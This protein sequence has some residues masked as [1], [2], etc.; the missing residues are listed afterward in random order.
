MIVKEIMTEDVIYVDKNEDLYH[1]LNLMKKHDITK[2]PVVEDKKLIGIVTDNMIAYKL[3]SI[4][5]KG[6]PA[7]R[8]HASLVTEKKFEAI[9]PETDIKHILQ[10]VGRPGL[11]MLPV[12]ENRKL[13]GVVTKADLLPLVK[14]KKPVKDIMKTPVYTISSEDR[15]I[16]ARR[17]MLNKNIARLPVVNHGMLLG[18]ISDKE[19]AFAF[20]YIKKAFPLGHQKHQLENLLVKDVMKTPAIW[21]KPSLTV[22][23]VAK[24]MIKHNIGALPVIENNQLIGIVTRTDLIKTITSDPT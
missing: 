10:T 13:V 23:D 5:K 16:H 24:T 6:I 11:T 7:S 14:S 20:A 22:Q 18:M 4:R 2:I 9:A 19:I 15:V 21:I 17:T 1:I 12:L 3:G 8:L